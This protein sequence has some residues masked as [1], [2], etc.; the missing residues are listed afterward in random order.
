M[1]WALTQAGL[2]SWRPEWEWRLF[3]WLGGPE[4]LLS[5]VGVGG[6]LE[7]GCQWGQPGGRLGAFM[8]RGRLPHCGPRK[9]PVQGV[10]V[11]P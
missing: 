7:C 8:G 3:A 9:K 2:V 11:E 1:G 5:P 6:C 4:V 10:A